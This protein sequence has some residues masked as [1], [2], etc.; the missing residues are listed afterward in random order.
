MIWLIKSILKATIAAFKVFKKEI[1]N[2][3]WHVRYNK[4]MENRK[5]LH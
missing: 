3:I 1:A 5:V 2:D 4:E